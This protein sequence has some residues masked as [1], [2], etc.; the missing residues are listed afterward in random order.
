MAC[1]K[2]RR[3]LGPPGRCVAAGTIHRHHSGRAHSDQMR[4]GHKRALPAL[5]NEVDRLA[6]EI[7]GH[8]FSSGDDDRV[9]YERDEKCSSPAL[10]LFAAWATAISRHAK[11]VGSS[12][13]NTGRLL[14]TDC[15]A[16][17]PPNSLPTRW[18]AQSNGAPGRG[19]GSRVRGTTRDRRGVPPSRGPTVPPDPGCRIPRQS[20]P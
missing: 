14:T 18:R 7:P 1:W 10:V 5:L 12:G 4:P 6:L 3:L 9:L 11:A 13:N 8:P 17:A 15:V 20:S 2:P 19:S 16:A